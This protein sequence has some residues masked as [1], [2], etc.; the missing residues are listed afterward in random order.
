MSVIEQV[1]RPQYA[2]PQPTSLMKFWKVASRAIHA[3][4]RQNQWAVFD[5]NY[6]TAD[7]GPNDS[8][9]LNLEAST[10]PR[11]LQ[12]TGQLWE[13][14]EQVYLHGVSAAAPAIGAAQRL[15]KSLQGSISGFEDQ[16]ATA[17]AEAG[18]E[19][20]SLLRKAATC[21]PASLSQWHNA[22]VSDEI[23]WSLMED[24]DAASL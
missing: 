15:P 10:A 7:Y 2:T 11:M 6:G 9:A 13:R 24:D 22:S 16:L 20:D 1:D 23:I 18:L 4:Q 17:A 21:L 19:L 14:L 5:V 8:T 3:H 12:S